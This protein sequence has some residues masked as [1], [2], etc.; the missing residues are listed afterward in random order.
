MWT[1]KWGKCFLRCVGIKPQ[2]EDILKDCRKSVAECSQG[3][4]RLWKA[5]LCLA[6]HTKSYQA[7]NNHFIIL[8]EGYKKLQSAHNRCFAPM[9]STAKKIVT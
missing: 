9:L 5:G 3:L 6:K 1:N 4:C 7:R 2:T 8:N